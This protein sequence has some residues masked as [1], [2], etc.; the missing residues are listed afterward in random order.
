MLLEVF[1]ERFKALYVFTK[2]LA[3]CLQRRIDLGNQVLG[4]GR[5]VNHVKG[6]DQIE[7]RILG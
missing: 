6:G 1:F 7:G 3:I 5:I 2:P 4:I